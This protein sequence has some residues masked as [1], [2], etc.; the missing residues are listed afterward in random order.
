MP[1]DDD[2]QDDLD[3][4]AEE[5]LEDCGAL[6]V[7]TL[8]MAEYQSLIP[9]ERLDALVLLCN[10]AVEGPSVRACLDCRMEEQQRVCKQI[11]DEIKAERRERR[12]MAA[13]KGRSRDETQEKRPEGVAGEMNL[14]SPNSLSLQQTP[15]QGTVLEHPH[16]QAGTDGAKAHGTVSAASELQ[17]DEGL[18]SAAAEHR[19]SQQRAETLRRVESAN[20]IRLEPLGLDRRYNRYYQLAAGSET[21]SPRIFIESYHDGTLRVVSNPEQLR[22]LL[23]ALDPRGAREGALHGRIVQMKDALKTNTEGVCK[24]PGAGETLRSGNDRAKRRRTEQEQRQWINSATPVVAEAQHAA[25]NLAGYDVKNYVQEPPEEDGAPAQGEVDSLRL[26]KLKRDILLVES[27]IPESAFRDAGS[28]IRREWTGR[29][30]RSNL[31]SE[32]RQCL[33][34]LG[35]ALSK[36]SLAQ[37]FAQKPVLVKGAWLP[38]PKSDPAD[39]TEVRPE[40]P[41]S[42]DPLAWLPAT[43]SSLFLWLLA[44]DAAIVYKPGVPPAR[45]TLPAYNFI[46]RPT[47]PSLTE[48]ESGQ[49]TYLSPTGKRTAIINQ[50]ASATGDGLQPAECSPE[51]GALGTGRGFGRAG[52]CKGRGR[53][54]GIQRSKGRRRGRGQGRRGRGRGAQGHRGRGKATATLEAERAADTKRETVEYLDAFSDGSDPLAMVDDQND[55]DFSCR[56]PK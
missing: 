54:R 30:R 45:E 46:Q 55:K 13:E 39:G 56:T 50:E 37:G 1:P 34:E 16:A 19:R 36:E 25:S 20:A 4:E 9:S 8:M 22:S 31:L 23:N 18:S 44:L 52:R 15:G 5:G 43:S 2:E 6:W 47:P 33:G 11:L 29:V 27:A 42:S 21:G 32:L 35:A 41:R 40:S 38:M 17:S 28:W 14:Q 10:M 53:A 24:R 3:F 12:K 49:T 51:L 48:L 7:K 26:W